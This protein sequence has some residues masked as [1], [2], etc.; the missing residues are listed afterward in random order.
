M[1][2]PFVFF[3]S[4][5]KSNRDERRIVKETLRRGDEPEPQYRT[6]KYWID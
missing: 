4:W 5:R 6:G 3:G 1:K 2:N